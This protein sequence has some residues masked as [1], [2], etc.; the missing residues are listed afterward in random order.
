V[1]NRLSPIVVAGLQVGAQWQ[2]AEFYLDSGAAFTLMRA[3]SA[4][5]CG[6]DYARGRKVFA[7]V[8]DGSFIPVYLNDLAMQIG[9]VKSQARVGFSEKLGLRF[10]LLGRLD[11]FRRFRICFHEERQLVTFQPL[12]AVRRQAGSARI[13]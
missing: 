3:K 8:G 4:E 7:Q 6:L 2:V 11:V 1:S 5:E 9:A 12:V 13:P 10:H